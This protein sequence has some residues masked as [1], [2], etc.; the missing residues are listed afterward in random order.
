MASG[1]LAL[2]PFHAATGFAA[3]A[4]RLAARNMRVTVVASVVLICGAFA[5]ASAL[6]MR[7]DRA[8]A[9]SEARY[10][11]ARRARDAARQAADALDRI[12]REA[13]K[14]SIPICA[15][16]RSSR[17]TARCGGP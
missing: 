2:R 1:S 3:F 15:T 17:R 12:A 6:Q 16:S 5:A 8:H 4:A 14:A 13:R 11:E 7:F 10:F 9:A